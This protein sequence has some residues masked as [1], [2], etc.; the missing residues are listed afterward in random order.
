MRE[1]LVLIDGCEFG[2]FALRL[3]VEFPGFAGNVGPF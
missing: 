3:V 2:E 1:S